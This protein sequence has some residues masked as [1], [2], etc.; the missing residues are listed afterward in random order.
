MRSLLVGRSLITGLLIRSNWMF[1]YIV[2]RNATSWSRSV[3]VSSISGTSLI[4]SGSFT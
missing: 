3:S 1:I 4:R 2:L